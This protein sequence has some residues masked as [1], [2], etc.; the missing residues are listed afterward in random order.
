MGI[1][2][3][4]AIYKYGKRRQRISA[5]RERDLD[6]AFDVCDQ[7]A[8]YRYEHGPAPSFDCPEQN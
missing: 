7:C 1:L 3:T 6:P 4:Y 5:E 2:T 8:H